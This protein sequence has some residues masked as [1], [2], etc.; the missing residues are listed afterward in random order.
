MALL[1][2]SSFYRHRDEDCEGGLV[3]YERDWDEPIPGCTD[4]PDAALGWDY[5]SEI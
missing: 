5:V 1:T 3:C 2:Q 4:N